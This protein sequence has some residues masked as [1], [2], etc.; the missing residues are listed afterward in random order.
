MLSYVEYLS[1]RQEHFYVPLDALPTGLE[2]V[3]PQYKKLV[4][5]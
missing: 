4:H 1:L 3:I 5:L 2:C